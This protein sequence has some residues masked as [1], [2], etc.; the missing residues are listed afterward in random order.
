MSLLFSRCNSIVT[1]KKNKRHMAEV[2]A[3]PL[4]H[5]VTAKKK[6]NGIFEQLGAYIQESATF[7]ED[8]YR[9]AELDP[10]TTEEQ[11]LDVKGYL[12]K[13]RGIS[14]VLARR[15]MKVAF[16]GR[17]SNGKS[18]V[19]NAML[20]DKVLPSG[21]G[22]TTNCFL[23]VEGTDGHEAF[24][25]TE[26]SEEKRSAKTV[27][28]LAHALHQDKQLHA[29]SLVSVMWP[30]SKCPLLK[31]DL[32]LMDRCGGSTWSVVP[33]SW[34][35][36]WAWWIDPRPGTASSLCL[37]RRCSTPGFR[38]PRACLKEKAFK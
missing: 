25:L 31:D 22:H 30:N 5:F 20:W 8:T 35:M 32:V 15:H 26:G 28:Q 19:I 24:L 16:F 9:N 18:T 23:R 29:G 1:V 36:S 4:K 37:L 38:K 34:W 12:S 13:V 7:L 17:T 14:E 27:N 21:I 33:A 10:V 2:N 11:V 3:S 6:I